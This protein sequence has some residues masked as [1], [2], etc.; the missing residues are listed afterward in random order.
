MKKLMSLLLSSVLCL[1][2]AMPT[3]AFGADTIDDI[4][5]QIE[6][7]HNIIDDVDVD[8]IEDEQKDIDDMPTVSITMN[9]KGE[10]Q[11][12]NS[13]EGIM[14]EPSTE[15]NEDDDEVINDETTE[16]KTDDEVV[17]DET[18]EDKT[19]DEVVNN[20]TTEDKTDDE[21]VNNETTEDKTDDE[22]VNDETTEDKT[23]D[24]VVNDET[25]EDKA[26]D[27]V[28]NDEIKQDITD[29]S[30]T[31]NT[32]NIETEDTQEKAAPIQ[33][34]LT[35]YYGVYIE[36]KSENTELP[37]I[38]EN[39][40]GKGSNMQKYTYYSKETHYNHEVTVKVRTE[41]LG[42]NE[43]SSLSAGKFGFCKDYNEVID[44]SNNAVLV[45]SVDYV[46]TNLDPEE[47][48][49]RFECS[50]EPAQDQMKTVTRVFVIKLK[51]SE[52]SGDSA[53]A[54]TS[55]EFIVDN[56]KTGLLLTGA[57]SRMEY[58]KE[59][60]D[61]WIDCTDSDIV[62]AAPEANTNYYVRYKAQGNTPASQ[63]KKITAYA[64]PAASIIRIDAATERLVQAVG[65]TFDK[66]YEMKVDN[67][68]YF[69]VT[70]EILETG[71]AP[72][73]DKVPTGTQQTL[74]IRKK[75]T[76]TIPAGFERQIVLLPR[77]ATPTSLKYDKVTFQ[78]TGVTS[79]MEYL[80]PT[81]SSWTSISKD[82]NLSSLA[83]TENA[84][85]IK[86]RVKQ[87]TTNSASRPYVF[88]IPKL[89]PA[90]TWKIDY[91]NELLTGFTANQ[92]YEWRKYGTTTWKTFNGPSV[93]LS[94]LG[95]TGNGYLNIYIRRPKTNT[96]PHSA[97]SYISI[98][99]RP[100][101]P[102]VS[103]VCND[104]RYKDD[105]VIKDIDNS[106]QYSL[107]LGNTWKNVTSTEMVTDFRSA[108]YKIYFRYKATDSAFLSKNAIFTIG[109]RAK[110]PT[111]SIN[112]TT[113]ILNT[114]SVMEY[115][116]NNVNFTHC[117]GNMDMKAVIDAIPTGGSKTIYIRKFATETSPY[118][119][120]K[121]IKIYARSNAP[122]T[123][124]YD[125]ATQKINGMTTA[126][127]YRANTEETWHTLSKGT[128]ISVA[129]YIKNNPNT[130][131]EIRYKATATSSASKPLFI[132]L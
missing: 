7:E 61:T 48:Q 129:G 58:R 63:T 66:T 79:G 122:T 40:D 54:P 109:T 72:F 60:T 36:S 41:G 110:A 67:G 43:K 71:A 22:V 128:S 94:E 56:N 4:D 65:Y 90:P 120:T 23:D 55:P 59:E 1:S 118:S 32:E 64:R 104:P 91:K 127:M 15:N 5:T 88:T 98:A 46:I 21:V 115:S 13:D 76:D 29:K 87:T 74:Y 123:P 107:D 50:I 82:I 6:Q 42:V 51:G 31:E 45:R 10:I 124:K 102:T 73:L 84:V 47:K 70:D 106:M 80:N 49:V 85:E 117:S 35:D 103:F 126:M 34:V 101:G 33:G 112:K 37:S 132:K 3:V 125:S 38:R 52:E 14:I 26:D 39:I 130:T 111:V 62:F 20:E 27:E 105:V 12:I 96:Q 108:S 78:L 113:E 89:S 2:L 53:A 24:E 131:I 116:Y 28:V 69:D 44:P 93:S 119:L 121:E 100:N 114:T 57:D 99:P 30:Q 68:E 81:K 97:A 18:T 95:Y 16:D 77:A 8:T 11:D 19:D 75:A 83:T 86:V 25:T 9:E 92:N 17:N